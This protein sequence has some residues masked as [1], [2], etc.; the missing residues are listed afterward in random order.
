MIARKGSRFSQL[1]TVCFSIWLVAFECVAAAG[2]PELPDPGQPRMTREQ[3][4]Q[5]GLQAGAQVYAQMP[6]YPIP[7][8]KRNI[9]RLSVSGW[10]RP[11]RRTVPGRFNFTS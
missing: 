4:T 7:V 9:F 3:Q 1:L 11:S 6:G 5:L 8:L 2:A 10:L